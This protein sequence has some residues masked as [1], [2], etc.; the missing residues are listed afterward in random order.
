MGRSI[1]FGTANFFV[2]DGA[3]SAVALARTTHLALMAHSDDLEFWAYSGI[4]ECYG[5]KGKWFSGITLTDGAGSV[6]P[7]G[8][9]R[10]SLVEIRREEQREAARIGRYSFMLQ[11]GIPSSGLMGELNTEV[12]EV[13]C[14]VLASAAPEVL[15]LH[16][17]FDRHV[18][19]L[20]VLRHALA[21]LRQVSPR[22]RLVLGCEGWRDL[23]WLPKSRKVILPVGRLP[24]LAESL[25]QVF[26]SQIAGKRYDHA[27]SGRRA[28]HA[29]FQEA[30]D[31][32]AASGC[33]LA[34]D[35]TALADPE[36]PSVDEF[37]QTLLQEFGA[38]IAAEWAA[39]TTPRCALPKNH[40]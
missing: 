8:T 14:Q 24:Q 2:P 5:E 18:T 13:L 17:P 3:S 16:N 15:Y 22:P 40:E 31:S 23:D 30:R 39:A 36:G 19:H 27:V 34:M 6:L 7:P 26:Q 20:A 38:E 10:K 12:V 9:T 28:A 32:D 21:A 1:D 4:E 11:P 35:L 29:T 25:C 33:I 37:V